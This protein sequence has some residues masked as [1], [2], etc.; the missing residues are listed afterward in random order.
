[1][2]SRKVVNKRSRTFLGEWCFYWKCYISSVLLSIKITTDA[3]H[4][5]CFFVIVIMQKYCRVSRELDAVKQEAS[6]LRDQMT[7]VKHDIEKVSWS[8]TLK[9]FVIL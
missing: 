6:L 3:P 4:Y 8:F 2:S 1:M 7:M 5:G 9:T